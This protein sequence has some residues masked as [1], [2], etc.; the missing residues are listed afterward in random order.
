MT[1]HTPLSEVH[2]TDCL[3]FMRQLPADSFDL[4]I[5]DPPYFSG[6]ERRAFY[7]SRISSN[8]V[9]RIYHKS[10]AWQIPTAEYF[11]QLERVSRRYIIWGCNYFDHIFHSGRIVWD[12]CN[13]ASSFSDCEIAA[14]NLFSS[15]R[16]FRYMW[17]GMC[18]GLSIAEGHIQQGNKALNEVRIHPTQKPVALYGWMLM[19]FAKPRWKILDTHLGSGSSR[20]AAYRLGFDFT[21][22]EIDPHYYQAAEERFQKEALGHL[23]T[24][25]GQH[26]RQTTILDLL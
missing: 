19:N 25:Q 3:D 12:K 20:I 16:L 21:G 15:V 5:C 10:P 9:R 14:T 26:F 23:I 22:C 11:Q 17:N 18:Q 4:A 2:H 6:P 13:G 24:P 7:G 1:H 8:G